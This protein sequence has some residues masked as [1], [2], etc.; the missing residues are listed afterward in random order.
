MI[1]CTV[2]VAILVVTVNANLV[3]WR[4]LTRDDGDPSRQMKRCG[5][6]L[7]AVV[8]ASLSGFLYSALAAS[9]WILAPKGGAELI[10]SL[11]V[12]LSPLMALGLGVWLPLLSLAANR[13][14]AKP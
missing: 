13:R 14:R 12:Q 6:S 11:V 8:M 7:A 10:G 9:S 4:A 1:A 5:Y 3:S 2:A